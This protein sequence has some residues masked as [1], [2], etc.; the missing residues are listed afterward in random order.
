MSE[1]EENIESPEAEGEGNI[2]QEVIRAI[3]ISMTVEVGSTSLKL[4]DLLRLSQGSVLELDRSVGELMDVKINNT[5]IA[6]GE[7]VTVGDKLGISVVEIVA[8]LERVKP[9]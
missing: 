1:N 7:V 8:P 9:V 4:R 6:K 2:D 5:V 3:P